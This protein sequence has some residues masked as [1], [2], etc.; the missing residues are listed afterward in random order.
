MA[1]S[2]IVPKAM[3]QPMRR[4]CRR[5]GPGGRAASAPPGPRARRLVRQ[6]A[7]AGAREQEQRAGRRR[8]EWAGTDPVTAVT[9]EV[10][11]AAASSP[12]LKVA[13]SC[14]MAVRPWVLSS[15]G[16]LRVH[17]DV[18]AADRDPVGAH[19][20][21]RGAGSSVRRTARPARRSGRWRR[22]GRAAASRAAASGRRPAGRRP[23]HRPAGH[24]QQPHSPAPRSSRVFSAGSRAT[25]VPY[26]K[27][28]KQNSRDRP[29]G[30]GEGGCGHQ[31]AFRR[32]VTWADMYTAPL[33]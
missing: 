26:W 10:S 8:R 1:P 22:R 5:A 6:Q 25:Q 7:R 18:E 4:W 11:S 13:C 24:Q 16:A 23:P 29:L 15:R 9:P 2:V 12:P 31:L 14:D 17:G 21:Q 20:E 30:A 32:V 3:A 33:P 19:H 27:P 28:R